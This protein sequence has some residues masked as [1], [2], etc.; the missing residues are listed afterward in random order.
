VASST[1][2]PKPV[3]KETAPAGRGVLLKWLIPI[4]LALVLRLI[5]TPAG[6]SPVAWHYFAL[7]VAVIAGLITE[8]I[9][10]P[11]VGFV[12]V[13][14]AAAFLFVGKTPA[15][16]LRWALSGFAN[17]T[18]WLIF[19][20]NMFAVG[21]EVTGLGRRI[22]LV[23][24]KKLGRSTL[25]LAYAIGLADLILAPFMPSVTA[26][27]GGTIYPIV[28]SIPPIY[29]C[30]PTENPRKIGSYLLWTTFA[31]ASI[32]SG[33][34]MTSF[35][36]NV[37]ATEIARKITHVDVNWTTW[38]MGSL[39]VCLLLFAATPLLC[40]YLYP[41]TIKRSTE[42]SAW[43]ATEL[44]QM[45]RITRRELTMALLALGA[46]GSWISASRWISATTVALVV[47]SLMVLTKVV[48]WND[49]I[50]AKQ[51]WNVFVWFATLVVMAEGLSAV[52]F[53]SWFATRS[54]TLTTHIPLTATM[55]AIVAVFFAVHY[56]IAS[57]TAQT[58]ALLPVFLTAA[59]AVNGLPIRP[60][61]LLLLYSL[62]LMGVIT[63]YANGPAPIYFS[64][65]YIPSK[66]F[67][68]LGLILG[69]FNLFV[70]LV[71]GLPFALHFLR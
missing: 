64:S 19:A 32:T 27:S 59:V 46:L 13:S 23:F 33:M 52:G 12:G 39:P 62:G 24:V 28:K 18:V 66:D 10:G 58:A 35:A 70:L 45:G 49:I 50:N 26:R 25:G 40:Y 31:M 7:F 36:P 47:I 16:G 15:E 14:F 53:L 61:T 37:L 48:T 29:G 1:T 8:P 21:Y 3:Q 68:R 67:W 63:P 56:L 71:V 6:L 57:G 43:A 20:A 2:L 4:A 30:S 5:P 60:V 22:A 51:A 55:I 54:A 17:D 38:A 41:P 69:L 65:G 34:F 9:P 11:A 42:V 44:V